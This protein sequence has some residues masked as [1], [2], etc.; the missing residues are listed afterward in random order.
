MKKEKNSEGL[1]A[2]GEYWAVWSETL[3]LMSSGTS[4]AMN[5]KYAEARKKRSVLD[6]V[7]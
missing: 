6:A 2:L 4:E 1:R 3:Q 7:N 5:A